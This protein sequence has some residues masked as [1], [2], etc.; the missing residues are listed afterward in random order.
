MTRAKLKT[1]MEMLRRLKAKYQRDGN[2]PRVI[3]FEHLMRQTQQ[4]L[5]AIEMNGTGVIQ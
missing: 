2:T 1:R 5:M 3:A 4:R